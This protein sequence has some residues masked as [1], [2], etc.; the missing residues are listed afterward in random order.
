MFQQPFIRATVN[1]NPVA[2]LLYSALVSA[3]IHDAPGQDGDTAELT[4]DD[5]DNLV[6]LPSKGA[7]L[8]LVFGNGSLG[9]QKMGRFVVEGTTIEGGADGEFIIVSGRS[10]DMR[11]DVKEPASEHFDEMTI[12][13]IVRQLAGRHGY[14]AV[15][16]PA[17][18]AMK[19]P[20]VARYGQGTTDFLTRIADRVGG[21][22]AV[23]DGKFLLLPHG[24]LPA[25]TIDRYECESWSF[26]VEPRPLYGKVEAGWFDRA[27]G[28]V[29]FE[30]HD[31]GLAGA[32]RRMRRTFATQ[33]EAKAAAKSE[34]DRL[35]RATGSGSITLY[36]RPDI[37]ADA[38]IVTTRFRREA[39]GLWRCAGVDHTFEDTY[40]TTIELE[41][42]EEGKT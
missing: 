28:Q 35:G 38:P 8:G 23:K 3:R 31:T 15:V 13:D 4:F 20:Y 39:N 34:G 26:Q 37:M 22:F 16:D 17:I 36:G 19:L 12:G 10:A 33:A 29:Q 27:K 40:M 14:G 9:G 5:K 2:D 7:A 41:A 42:P 18:A 6:A 1:G 11:S 25:V 21:L 32:A 30:N 24:L